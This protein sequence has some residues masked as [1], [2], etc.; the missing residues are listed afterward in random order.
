MANEKADLRRQ[1]RGPCDIA[2]ICLTKMR[3]SMQDIDITLFDTIFIKW[4]SVLRP[5][6]SCAPYIG[7]S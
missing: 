4:Y 2:D 6:I 7:N 3:A 5:W 1:P